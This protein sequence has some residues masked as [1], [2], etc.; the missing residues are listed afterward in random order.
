M[1]TQISQVGN[2]AALQGHWYA[3]V[4][5]EGRGAAERCPFRAS[6]PALANG[7]DL[8]G[9]AATGSGKR[10]SRQVAVD[11]ATAQRRTEDDGAARRGHTGRVRVRHPRASQDPIANRCQRVAPYSRWSTGD[12]K[13]RNRSQDAVSPSLSFSN[14][15][16]YNPHTPHTCTRAPLSGIL[17]TC[18]LRADFLLKTPPA[19]GHM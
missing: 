18:F 9:R 17:G 6:G 7:G 3:E 4:E 13:T 1:C 16:L 19:R 11:E 10:R 12:R 2:D 15:R 14:N 8:P 5:E